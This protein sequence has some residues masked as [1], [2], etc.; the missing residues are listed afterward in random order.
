MMWIV[1]LTAAVGIG[2]VCWTLIWWQVRRDVRWDAELRARLAEQ[3]AFDRIVLDK[4]EMVLPRHR[5]NR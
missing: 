4:D 5:W 1:T 3:A 2:V